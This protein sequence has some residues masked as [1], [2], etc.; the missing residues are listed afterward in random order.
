M[1]LSGILFLSQI[2]IALLRNHIGGII[3]TNIGNSNITPY[4]VSLFT[5]W[6]REVPWYA[7]T[8]IVNRSDLEVYP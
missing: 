1:A 6:Y 5:V 8:A 3:G 4:P 7:L 2:K